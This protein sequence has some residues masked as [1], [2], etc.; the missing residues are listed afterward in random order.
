MHV[1]ANDGM[2]VSID[3]YKCSNIHLVSF[4]HI[5]L[6]H[7]ELSTKVAIDSFVGIQLLNSFSD[8]ITVSWGT[9]ALKHHMPII[10]FT[11][12]WMWHIPYGTD[13]QYWTAQEQTFRDIEIQLTS[14]S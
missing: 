4:R 1:Q 14:I 10:M 6:I 3:V 8:D 11:K 5:P 7:V 9:S 2:L 13:V 12:H